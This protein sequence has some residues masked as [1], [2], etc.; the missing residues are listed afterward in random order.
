MDKSSINSSGRTVLRKG[1]PWSDTGG[2]KGWNFFFISYTRSDS[3]LLSFVDFS[4][5]LPERNDSFSLMLCNKVFTTI[6]L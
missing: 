3:T 1:H 5:A 6:R 2:D 4:I